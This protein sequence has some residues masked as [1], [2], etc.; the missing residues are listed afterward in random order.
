MGF[1]G[2]AGADGGG[3]GDVL[4]FKSEVFFR[5]SATVFIQRLAHQTHDVGQLVKDRKTY[6]HISIS[7]ASEVC[8]VPADMRGIVDCSECEVT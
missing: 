4:A 3:A 8:H 6:F 5:Q 2:G 1:R 7:P